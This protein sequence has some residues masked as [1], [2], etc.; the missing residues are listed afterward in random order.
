MAGGHNSIAHPRKR[1]VLVVDD[2]SRVR[3]S[4]ADLLSASGIGTVC[5]SSAGAL[6]DSDALANSHCV[7]S[8]VRMPGIDGWKLQEIVSATHPHVLVIFISSFKDQQAAER[9]FARGAFAFLY[10][11][12]DGEELLGIVEAA[13]SQV[14]DS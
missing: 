8:D 7:I 3:E 1:L 5:F 4:L 11:P 6:L 13:L 12:F 10:K 2:D 9:A 14:A